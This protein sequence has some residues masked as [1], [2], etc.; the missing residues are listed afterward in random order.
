MAGLLRDHRGAMTYWLL[1]WMILFLGLAGL[2]I[3][4]TNAY[5]NRAMLQITGDIAAHA[6][7]AAIIEGRT[8]SEIRSAAVEVAVAA[9]DDAQA[10]DVS[11]H[12]F[13]FS[14]YQALG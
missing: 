1:S 7:A 8:L 14:A 3:D 12:P 5:R 10:F 4:T 6:G 11:W 13:G 2:A 9:V